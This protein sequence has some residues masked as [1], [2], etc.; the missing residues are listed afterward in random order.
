MKS[1]I[2]KIAKLILRVL[3]VLMIGFVS[4]IIGLIAGAIVGGTLAGIYEI[5]SGTEF[6][7]NG[8]AGYEGTGQIGFILGALTGM[9]GSGVW[10]FGRRRNAQENKT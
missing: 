7:F 4:A 9:V 1:L 8:R 5:V 2:I 10:L 3:A 6:V